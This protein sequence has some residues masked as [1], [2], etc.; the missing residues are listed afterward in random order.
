M[1]TDPLLRLRQGLHRHFGLGAAVFVDSFLW[2]CGIVTVDIVR[3]DDWLQRR[4]PDYGDNESMQEFV[5]RRYGPAAEAFLARWI[6]GVR[7]DDQHAKSKGISGGEARADQTASPPA[8]FHAAN[9][10]AHAAT[11][12]LDGASARMPTTPR[13]SIQ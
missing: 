1:N 6:K 11:K 2:Q 13:R 9:A 8:H 4:N 5:R 12:W 3:L 10:A 7:R